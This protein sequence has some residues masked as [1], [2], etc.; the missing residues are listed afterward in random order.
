MYMNNACPHLDFH[1]NHEILL[2]HFPNLSLKILSYSFL[3]FPPQY[4]RCI[5]IKRT[6]RFELG[7]D[8]KK[9]GDAL[10]FGGKYR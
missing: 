8:T 2:K 9:K 5:P 3:N 4:K 10:S 1:L 7:G 6:K